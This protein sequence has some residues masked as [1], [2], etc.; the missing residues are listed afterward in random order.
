MI[1]QIIYEIY[2][3]R[4]DEEYTY[5]YDNIEDA[6][7]DYIYYKAREYWDYTELIETIIYDDEHIHRSVIG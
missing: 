5:M 1:K 4:A 3:T 2:L 7:A 6:Q